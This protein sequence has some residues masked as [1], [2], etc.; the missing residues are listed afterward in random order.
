MTE[1]STLIVDRRRLE[2]E[3]P[4]QLLSSYYWITQW[5]I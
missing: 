3:D 4:C 1:I 2:I 5:S